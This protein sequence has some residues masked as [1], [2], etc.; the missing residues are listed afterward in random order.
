MQKLDEIVEAL[1]M[2]R[3]ERAASAENLAAWPLARAFNDDEAAAAPHAPLFANS[4][5]R[6]FNDGD[7]DKR[8]NLRRLAHQAARGFGKK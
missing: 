8:S 4:R 1:Q 2:E 6:R 7:M 3:N 5:A